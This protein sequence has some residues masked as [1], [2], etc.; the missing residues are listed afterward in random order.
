MFA[1]FSAIVSLVGALVGG[2]VQFAPVET[3]MAVEQAAETVVETHWASNGEYSKIWV[4]NEIEASG[5]IIPKNVT[6]IITDTDNCGSELSPENTGGG[7]TVRFTDGS[8]SV[9]VSPTA[10]EDGTGAHILF[11]ELGH[12]IHNLGEC[13]AEYFAHDYSAVDQWSY[14]ACNV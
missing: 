13:D 1:K 14:P 7:C 11:H 5:V 10:L 3:R 12:A 2:G 4:A 6:I 9:L 8:I